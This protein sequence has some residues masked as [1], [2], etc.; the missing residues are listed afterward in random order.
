MKATLSLALGLS[1]LLGALSQIGDGEY[2]CRAVPVFSTVHNSPVAV[3][4]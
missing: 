3:W 1:I 4:G 2:R